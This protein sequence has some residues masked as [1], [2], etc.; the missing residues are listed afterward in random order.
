MRRTNGLLFQDKIESWGIKMAR[1]KECC[2]KYMK[3]ESHQ[4]ETGTD[5][6][7]LKCEKCARELVV[8]TA[9][10]EGKKPECIAKCGVPQMFSCRFNYDSVE[11]KV[12]KVAEVVNEQQVRKQTAY[13]AEKDSILELL[14]GLFKDNVQ[15]VTVVINDVG[16]FVISA[17]KSEV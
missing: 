14:K 8:M 6:I 15:G 17:N 3:V 2:R 9:L 16:S 12:R 10:S 5:I 1:S 11:C 13:M 7:G 4:I